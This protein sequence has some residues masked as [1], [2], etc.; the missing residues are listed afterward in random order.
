[1]AR[2]TSEKQQFLVGARL[3]CFHSDREYDSSAAVRS[4]AYLQCQGRQPA[5]LSVHFHVNQDSDSG[6]YCRQSGSFGSQYE[7]RSNVVVRGAQSSF[8]YPEQLV[9]LRA[10]G[11]E[12]GRDAVF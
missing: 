11:Y 2:R 10:L 9:Y 4:S 3:L 5:R 7:C 6:I 1:M 8:G 12:R